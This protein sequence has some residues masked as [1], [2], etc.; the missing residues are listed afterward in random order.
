MRS[1]SLHLFRHMAPTR[2]QRFDEKGSEQ[3]AASVIAGGEACLEPVAER[4]QFI[5]LG[6][7]PML[8]GK[9]WEGK[10]EYSKLNPGLAWLP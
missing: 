7:D 10:R 2:L 3:A 4:P 9:G 8:F 1:G 6:D 5:D